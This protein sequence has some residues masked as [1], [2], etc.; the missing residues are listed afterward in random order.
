MFKV[1]NSILWSTAIVFLIGGGLY[2]TFKLKF[3]QLRL[4]SMIK[5]FK[6]DNREKISP[7]SALTMAL[8]ARIGVGS[9]SGIALAIY[10]GGPG[11]IFWMWISSIITSAN[12]FSESVLGIVYREKDGDVHK[13]GPAYYIDKG[14]NNKS[15]ARTYAILIIIAYIFGFMTIQAN[16]LATS[17]SNYV[18]IKPIIIGIILASI[19]AYSILKGVKQIV[20]LT[21][22]LVPIMGIV[23][24][25]LSI[26]IVI[27]N[28]EQI[29]NILLL[30]IKSAF[31]IKSFGTGI[32]ATFIIG[33]QRGVFSTEAGLGSGAIASSTTDSKDAVKIGLT[34]VVGIY[35]TSFIVCTATAFII[36][37]SNYTSLNLTNINGIEITQY[38]LQYHLNDLGIIILIFSIISF[39][40]STI[41]AGYYY[42]ESNL[43]FL[44]KNVKSS[45]ITIFKIL[46]IILLIIGSVRIIN[47][48]IQNSDTRK[49][50]TGL[51]YKLC[52]L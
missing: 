24:I 30:I 6:H 13:G 21:N 19:T 17:I 40:F 47:F 35:F 7:F 51:E 28:F 38:A 31:N 22:K 27:V 26:Y 4:P 34:Q 3:I 46:T 49:R 23:Y 52:N 12:A 8:A 14:L 44:D 2:F 29:S 5:S 43:K 42:G 18:N 11:T 48:M 16:T 32:I 45:H 37:T 50:N 10:M 9:L 33:I 36:L 25:V 41:I 1:F 15:L 39:A 20:S